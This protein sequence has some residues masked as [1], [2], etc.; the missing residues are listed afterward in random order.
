MCGRIKMFRALRC[1]VRMAVF[2]K[3]TRRVSKSSDFYLRRR[4]NFRKLFPAII[5][6]VNND[7]KLKNV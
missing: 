4:K 2:L 7:K 1:E 5:D 6:N 3:S